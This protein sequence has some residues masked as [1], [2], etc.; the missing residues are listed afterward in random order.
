MTEQTGERGYHTVAIDALAVGRQLHEAADDLLVPLLLPP[1]PHHAPQKSN[2]SPRKKMKDS[3][4]K[5]RPEISTG[6]ARYR[7]ALARLGPRFGR[8]WGIGGVGG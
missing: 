4:E 2:N 7:R 1:A 5:G 3:P 8:L 6:P